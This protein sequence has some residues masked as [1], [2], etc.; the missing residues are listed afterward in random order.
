MMSIF[1]FSKR[2]P[3][4]FVT[5]ASFEE[6]VKN[7]LTMTPKTLE[8]LRSHGITDEKS[9]SLEIFFYTNTKDKAEKLSEELNQMKYQTTAEISAY[10]KKQF[11]IRGWTE[12]IKMEEAVLIEW[13]KKMCELGYA[14]DCE[15]D[16]WGTY[17]E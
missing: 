17:L 16:G 2:E 14:H 3:K 13:T 7:Q 4:T 6:N 11:C 1:K 8:Q 15:F 9:L 5:Q 10:D 12:K